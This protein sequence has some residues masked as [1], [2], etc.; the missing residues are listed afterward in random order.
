MRLRTL[1]AALVLAGV[2]SLAQAAEKP[3]DP[4]VVSNAN[5]GATPVE[6]EQLLAAFHGQ[7]GIARV[8]DRMV[9]LSIADP[10][11]AEIF[12]A[13]DLERLRRTL[14]EQVGYLLGAGV[15]YTGRDMK[16]AHKDQGIN[17]AEFN[18]L[19]EN[20]Q[21]AMDEEKVPFRAQNQLLAKLAPMKRDVVVR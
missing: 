7:A 1:T 9:D 18:A 15:D 5:A 21:K 6:G 19:V 4:Y 11:I 3:V 20:L 17:T 13:T 14:K 10:R 12:R 2:A 16:T 8:V